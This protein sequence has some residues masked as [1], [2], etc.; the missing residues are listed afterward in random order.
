MQHIQIDII[1]DV[2]CPWCYLG[3]KR[4]ALALEEVKDSVAADIAWK[5]YQLEPNAP[6]EGFN[7]FDYLAKKIGGPERVKQSHDMLKGLGAEIG[8]PFALE[9]AGILPNTLDA[10]RLLHWAGKVDPEIQDKVAHAL[11]TANFVEGRNVGD[12]AVL[13]DIAEKCGMDRAEVERLLSTDTDRDTIR[14]GIAN[15]QRIGVTG[16]PFFVIDG[17]Y[18]ISGAQGVDVFAN[19]LKRIAEMKAKDSQPSL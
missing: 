5:P 8:L 12:H 7:T 6:P 16:V 18:A 11:F 19:A 1:S 14:N 4:L 3:Q 15:A 2:V 10:H 17:K 9:R 13:A